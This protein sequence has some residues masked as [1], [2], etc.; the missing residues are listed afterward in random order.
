M[1]LMGTEEQEYVRERLSGLP[2]PVRL[3]VFT[4]RGPCPSC[5]ATEELAREIAEVVPET[6]VRVVG[7]DEPAVALAYGVDRRPAVAVEPAEGP[8]PANGIRFFGFPG[9]YEF[10]SLLESMV[11]VAQAEPGLGGE[12]MGELLGLE[13]PLHLQVFV[14]QTCPYCPRMVQLAHRMAL[15]SPLVRA[16][17]VDVVEFPE[18]GMRY[19]V[20]GVPMTVIDDAAAVVG[21]VPESRL[22]TEVRR[23]RRRA[24]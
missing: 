22:L 21:A 19:G 4:R 23:A 11:R 20:Q 2:R 13:R 15:A 12:L 16:D 1:R 6:E 18:L 3:V 7:E 24:G 9:G 17:M 8:G 5:E 14:T 10:D